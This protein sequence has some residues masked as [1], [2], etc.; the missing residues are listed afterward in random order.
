[1]SA[2]L[3]QKVF[4]Y[5]TRSHYGKRGGAY[6][7]DL[8]IN[9]A[10]GFNQ[11]GVQFYASS[12]Y[13]RSSPYKEDYL[14]KHNPEVTPD[15]CDIVVMERQFFEES[16]SLPQDLF[17]PSRKYTTV[18]LDCQDGI[19]TLSW[20]PEFE[21]FDFILKTHYMR[22]FKYPDNFCPW[23]FG[24]SSR[25][26]KSTDS[27]QPFSTRKDRILA[28]FKFSPSNK[29]SHSLRKYAAKN[30]IAGMDKLM[31]VDATQDD[32]S[33]APKSPFDQLM[34]QQSG[35]RHIPSYYQRLGESKAC[36]AFG[37]M[38][39]GPQFTDLNGKVTY[40][41]SKAISKAGIKTNRV[42][43]WDS[44]RLWESLAAGCVTFHVD[45]QKYGMTL[46]APPQN[47]HHYIGIDLDDIQGSLRRISRH[48]ELMEK[49]SSQGRDWAIENYSPI[50]VAKRFLET[51]SP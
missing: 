6:F 39:L 30:F 42:T 37:G 33:I 20:L 24:L 50:A 23:A 9:L 27:A 25:V 3:S 22:Q 2:N 15:D 5:T 34:W 19:K 26:I 47:W 7:Q 18:F 17:H 4:F 16:R 46:P 32:V 28:N 36:A 13:W 35:K 48:P 10:E 11:L 29:F 44:W 43:Q 8:A 41:I 21:K 45:F 49:I 40:Y 51:V 14:L 12:D 1:M 31:E 38:F